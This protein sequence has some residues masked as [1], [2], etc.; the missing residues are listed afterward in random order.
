MT[1]VPRLV[2]RGLVNS[3]SKVFAPVLRTASI[4]KGAAVPFK[5]SFSRFLDESAQLADLVLPDHDP[6]EQWNDY[7]PR[8]GVRS[9]QQPVMQPVAVHRAPV[10]ALV[11][12]HSQV[13]VRVTEASRDRAEQ[14]S[15]HQSLPHFDLHLLHDVAAH[16]VWLR[17]ERF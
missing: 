13:R 6:L 12:E 14:A 10:G 5:V 17:L 15:L 7:V 1:S 8:A 3:N 9:L 4:S 11:L 2:A 16:H